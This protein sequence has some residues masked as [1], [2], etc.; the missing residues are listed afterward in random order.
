MSNKVLGQYTLLSDIPTDSLFYTVVSGVAYKTTLGAIQTGLNLSVLDL[1]DTP[2]SYATTALRSDPTKYY[3]LSVNSAGNATEFAQVRFTDLLNVP[4]TIASMESDSNGQRFLGVAQGASSVTAE[5]VDFTGLQDTPSSYSSA[6]LKLVRVNS[7][8]NAIEFVDSASVFTQTTG[9]TEL[10]DTP[11]SYAGHGGKYV[12][13]TSD[14]TGLEF[15]S[16]IS[17]TASVACGE[18]LNMSIPI[19]SSASAIDGFPRDRILLQQDN[20]NFFVYSHWMKPTGFDSGQEITI[21]LSFIGREHSPLNPRYYYNLYC[22]TGT[23]GSDPTTFDKSVDVPLLTDYVDTTGLTSTSVNL[24]KTHSFSSALNDDVVALYFCLER[25][26]GTSGAENSSGI[27]I[28][29]I[30]IT[31][32]QNAI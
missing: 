26:N 14:A 30:G 20:R 13:V 7:A 5:Y 32:Y 21:N 6:S 28:N 16:S 12:K 23:T 2:S 3:F 1:S 17:S 10:N 22:I 15:T 9:F 31:Y 25:T 19:A 8:A 11:N 27:D 4:S 18:T 24:K 29:G